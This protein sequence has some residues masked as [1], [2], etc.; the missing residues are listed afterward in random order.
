V[1]TDDGFLTFADAAVPETEGVFGPNDPLGVAYG[2][3]ATGE[4]RW[5]VY[6]CLSEQPYEWY[7]DGFTAWLE[8]LVAL[9]GRWI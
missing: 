4:R 8:T 6:R 9:Q 7:R 3:D 2:F 1:I 5:G